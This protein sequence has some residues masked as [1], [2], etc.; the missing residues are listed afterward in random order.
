MVLIYD[1]FFLSYVVK[2]IINTL[3]NIDN[4]EENKKAILD[5]SNWSEVAVN[6]ILK[7]FLTLK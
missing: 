5:F 4:L 6:W 7:Y 1:P 3:L 2:V